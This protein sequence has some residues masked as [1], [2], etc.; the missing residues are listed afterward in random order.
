MRRLGKDVHYFPDP[1]GVGVGEVEALAVESLLV[2]NMVERIRDEINRHD[3]EAPA[4]DAH[5]GHPW[6]QHLAHLLDELEEVVRTVDLVDITRLG[7]TDHEAGAVDAKRPLALI[8][9]D[10]FG[11]VLGLEVRVIEVFR[12]FEHVLAEHAVVEA[13]GG[14]RAHVV[15]ALGTH[16]LGELN[17][18]TRAPNVCD[19][20]RFSACL[21]V[22]DRGQ[23][24]HMLDLALELAQVGV[25]DAQ[26]FLAEITD[27]GNDLL[28]GRTPF[29]AKRIELADRCLADKHVDGLSALQQIANQKLPDETGRTGDEVGHAFLLAY[30]S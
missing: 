13:G 1:V 5:H 19:L 3:V 15:E 23:M 28:V 25:G 11:V 22:V 7:V 18:M 9:D 27:D 21:E 8:A 16:G 14:D 4:F 10:G 26:I 30:R 6:G 29:V 20:L 24:E 17:G 12:F 2:R